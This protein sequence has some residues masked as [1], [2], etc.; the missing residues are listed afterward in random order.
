MSDTTSTEAP[1]LPSQRTRILQAAAFVA[2]WIALGWVFHLSVYPY[3]LIGIP[4]CIAFQK[5]VRRQPL[6]RCWVREATALRFDWIALLIAVA[7]LVTPITAAF[8][9][10]GRAAWPL[11]LYFLCASI[12]AFGAAFALRRF[13]ATALRSL[14]ACL[15]TAGVFQ[16]SLMVCAAVVRYHFQQRPLALPL[17]AGVTIA[18][19]LLVL[20]PVCFVMEEVAFRGI[21]DSHI[22]HSGEN[23]SWLS[24]NSWLSAA[25]LSAL[26]GWWHLPILPVPHSLAQAAMMAVVVPLLSMVPGLAFSFCWRHSG[27]LAVPAFVHALLDAVRNALLG[28][29]G[30]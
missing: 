22:H 7:L 13:T 26:W 18:K 10:W 20:F 16:C 17:S 21:L 11:R 8:H 9:T 1:P 30:S 5:W 23:G 12:G 25:L 24:R 14:L 19:Q 15:A 27:N 6:A 3:L 2:L 28:S 29:L 4:L